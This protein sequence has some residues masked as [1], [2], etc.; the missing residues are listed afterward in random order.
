MGDAG[1][2]TGSGGHQRSVRPAPP[3]AQPPHTLQDTDQ[4]Q[5]SGGQQ[6]AR[7]ASWHQLSIS[8]LAI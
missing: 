6:T 3:L 2:M 1:P 8:R 4:F 5:H 7:Q